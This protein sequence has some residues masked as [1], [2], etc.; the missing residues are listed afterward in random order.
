MHDIE[1]HYQWLHLYNSVE[2]EQSPFFEQE[3]SEFEFTQTIYNY[4]I[5]PQ[6]DGFG[7]PTLYLKVLFIDYEAGVGIIELIGEWND[8]IHN[9]VMV[10][11]RALIEPMIDQGINK[12]IF[13]GDNLLNFHASEDAYYEEWFG[14]LEDGW[15]AFVNFRAHVLD[16]IKQYKI[17][18]Y[19][20]FGGELDE[21]QWRKLSPQQLYEKVN[22][23]IERRLA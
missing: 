7:S 1:P 13:L 9:D 2:D 17:D 19:L 6:W 16:E 3:H 10:M 15:I 8:L 21:L 14:E 5:H 23:I 22:H 4:L 12:Y 20:N 11:K 18:Y